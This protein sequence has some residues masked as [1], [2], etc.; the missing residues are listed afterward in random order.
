MSGLQNTV[1]V[2]PTVFAEGFTDVDF[3][4]RPQTATCAAVLDRRQH[5]FLGI[6]PFNCVS[7]QQ[8]CLGLRYLA[9]DSPSRAALR[10][11]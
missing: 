9:D 1:A 6:S 4:V 11:P 3:G 7:F 8:C 2:G 10:L 5:A